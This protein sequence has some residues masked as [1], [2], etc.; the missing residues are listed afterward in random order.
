M[1]RP[2]GRT[3]GQ[4]VV[5]SDWVTR[6]RPLTVCRIPS[7]AAAILWTGSFDR[8]PI[9]PSKKNHL[10]RLL[11]ESLQIW[12]ARPLR[13]RNRCIG[14]PH[15]DGVCLG[16]LGFEENH[17]SRSLIT[18]LQPELQVAW[19]MGPTGNPERWAADVVIPEEKV[20]MVEDIEGFNSELQM[21]SF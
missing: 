16:Q 14:T 9:D 4:S 11:E 5:R 7:I 2:R 19:W 20:C 6:E 12:A 10:F 18:H 3:P 15:A 17:T 1:F 8:P 21:K 13:T